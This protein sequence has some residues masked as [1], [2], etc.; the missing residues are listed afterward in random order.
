MVPAAR[1]IL[2]AAGAWL[3][4]VKHRLVLTR[5]PQLFDFPA[6]WVI[7]DCPRHFKVIHREAM[8]CDILGVIRRPFVESLPARMEGPEP[9]SCCDE[10]ANA[11]ADAR[12][13]LATVMGTGSA[14]IDH[15]IA[16][17]PLSCL[18]A[19]S[20]NAFVIW[21]FR[22]S[23]PSLG[24]PV[25]HRYPFRPFVS[26]ATPPSFYT[27]ASAA[28]KQSLSCCFNTSD[29]WPTTCWIFVCSMTKR[30]LHDA[31]EGP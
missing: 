29:R 8:P 21:H 12:S 13:F 25:G 24:K 5:T 10:T 26:H 7:I 3:I 6:L 27:I 1:T 17:L 20:V 30:L 18:Y 22:I 31:A 2:A 4:R 28:F 19:K 15:F 23:V 14:D 9:H 16:T 11:R